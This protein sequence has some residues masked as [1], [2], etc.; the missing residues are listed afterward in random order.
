M[1][2]DQLFDIVTAQARQSNAVRH[3]YTY[4]PLCVS[5]KPP[6]RPFDPLRPSKRLRNFEGG[7]LFRKFWQ[8]NGRG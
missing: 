3:V 1:R 5:V 6:L 2:L 4:A 7:N 8:S